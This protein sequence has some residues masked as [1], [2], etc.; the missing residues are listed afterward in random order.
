M[1]GVNVDQVARHRYNDR[2]GAAEGQPTF[3]L[4]IPPPISDTTVIFPPN[5]ECVNVREGASRGKC[6]TLPC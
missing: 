2:S 5:L 6:P 4:D 3:P 1:G